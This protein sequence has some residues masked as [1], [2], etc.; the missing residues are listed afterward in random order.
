GFWCPPRPGWIYTP[1]CYCWTPRG[2]L[3]V[4]GFW[5]R[6]LLTRGVPFAP[7]YFPPGLRATP[8]FRFRPGFALG[9]GGVLG[10]LWARPAAGHYAFGDYYGSRYARA[11]YQPWHSFGPRARDPLYSYYRNAYARTNPNWTRGL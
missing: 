3:F 11:G 8:G 6:C 9:I 7:V 2:C 5:D 1:P 10:S 4:R